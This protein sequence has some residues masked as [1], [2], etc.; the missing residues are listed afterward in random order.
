MLSAL[1]ISLISLL[2]YL[3]VRNKEKETDLDELAEKIVSKQKSIEKTEHK[4]ENTDTKTSEI[5][6]NQEQ[7]PTTET[8][9]SDLK[10]DLEN[11]GKNVTIVQNI[12]YNIQDS[13]IV[14]DMNTGINSDTE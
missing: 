10:Q 4:T 1:I 6:Q 14:G 5:T 7:V 8:H 3:V 11:A 2:L 9:D 13:S 12:T